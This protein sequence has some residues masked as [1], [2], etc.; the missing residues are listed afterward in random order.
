MFLI[1]F[2][3]FFDL[4]LTNFDKSLQAC[5]LVGYGANYKSCVSQGQGDHHHM[6]QEGRG[7]R[8]DGLK[9]GGNRSVCRHFLKLVPPTRFHSV[10]TSYYSSRQRGK[11]EAIVYLG[12]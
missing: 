9:N 11:R 12:L 3:T 1:F 6:E 8:K 2:S 7:G 4:F 5:F 10:R